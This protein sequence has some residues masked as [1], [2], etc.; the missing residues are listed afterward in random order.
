M[1]TVW[2]VQGEHFSVPGVPIS[3]HGSVDGANAKAAELVNAMLKDTGRVQ[4]KPKAAT[5]SD[6][7][8]VPM[9]WL[10]DYHGAAHC[11]VEVNALEVEA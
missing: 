11:W 4:G 2:I 1:A 3:A 10:Q 5:P 8:G 9:G 7:R 6:W